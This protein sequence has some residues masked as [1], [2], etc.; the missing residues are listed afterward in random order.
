MIGEYSEQRSFRWTDK[1]EIALRLRD[2]DLRLRIHELFFNAGW[3][4]CIGWKIIH[5][6]SLGTFV[7]YNAYIMCNGLAVTYGLSIGEYKLKSIFC[8][9][10]QLS[11]K[12]VTSAY[13]TCTN[14]DKNGN[15]CKKERYR[16]ERQWCKT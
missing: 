9:C 1:Q 14:F 10:Y 6:L 8:Q 7:I 3:K 5:R 15:I 13:V 16:F 4:Y 2:T 11:V 12:I